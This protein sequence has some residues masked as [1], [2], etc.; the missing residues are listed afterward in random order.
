MNQ[1]KTLWGWDGKKEDERDGYNLTPLFL[2]DVDVNEYLSKKK[3]IDVNEYEVLSVG[4]LQK[5][6]CWLKVCSSA[7]NSTAT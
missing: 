1:T 2:C 7:T 4:G 6:S 3:K 5:R